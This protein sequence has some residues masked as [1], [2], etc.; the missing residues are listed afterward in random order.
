M[1]ISLQIIIKLKNKNTS[2]IFLNAYTYFNNYMLSPS[3]GTKN[4]NILFNAE[5]DN[6]VVKI[7]IHS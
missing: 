2:N 5:D 6:I 3:A 7:R 4:W 1:T